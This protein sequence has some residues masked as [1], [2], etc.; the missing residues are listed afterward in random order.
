M[1]CLIHHMTSQQ[2]ST[3]LYSELILNETRTSLCS[4]QM[5]CFLAFHCL[6]LTFSE[7]I[8]AL[9]PET[10][11]EMYEPSDVRQTIQIILP[12]YLGLNSI[13]AW[14]SKPVPCA[15]P[16]TEDLKNPE[17]IILPNSPE[18]STIVEERILTTCTLFHSTVILFLS[19]HKMSKRIIWFRLKQN[20]T[21]Q[22]AVF[23]WLWLYRHGSASSSDSLNHPRWS[24]GKLCAVPL[25]FSPPRYPKDLYWDSAETP[26]ILEGG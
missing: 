11:T 20:N 8:F 15:C 25:L 24:P 13:T 17:S 9:I 7:I 4:R 3:V 26:S 18:S 23:I 22:A 16:R 1:K 2:L 10:N 5:F 19:F 12:K 14:K 21:Y 6:I